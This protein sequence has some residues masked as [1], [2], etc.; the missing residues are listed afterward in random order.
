MPDFGRG[1]HDVQ[2]IKLGRAV[3]FFISILLK[4]L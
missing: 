3:P 4:V 1:M 2:A